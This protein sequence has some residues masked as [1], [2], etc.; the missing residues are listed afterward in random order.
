MATVVASFLTGYGGGHPPVLQEGCI[1]FQCSFLT[2]QC[3]INLELINILKFKQLQWFFLA[4][5]LENDCMLK[6]LYFT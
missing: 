1:K 2:L 4:I 5:I 3:V 6:K